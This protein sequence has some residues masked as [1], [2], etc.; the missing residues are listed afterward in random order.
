MRYEDIISIILIAVSYYLFSNEFFKF[1]AEINEKKVSLPARSFSF[2]LIYLWFLFASFLELPL[3]MNWFVFLILLGL[4]LHVVCAYDFLISYALSLF[5]V[6]TSLAVNVFLRSLASILMDVPL[7]YFDNSR[8]SLK[9]YP[10]F[11]GFM[12][13]AALLYVLRRLQ[14]TLQL[15]KM[16]RYR[17]SLAFYTWTEVFI[18]TSL[19]IQLLAYSQSGNSLGV[20][21]WG[22][23][24]SVFSMVVLAITI[25]YSL[26]VAALQFYMDK[27]H[28]IRKKLIRDKKDI[29]KLWTLA[30]TD[31]LTGCNNRQ[32]L[33]KR[34]EEYA[35]YGSSITLAFIDVNGL[36]IIN[37]QYG[38]LEGDNYLIGVSQIL[39]EVIGGCNL[40]LFRYGGD[41]FVLMSNTLSVKEITGLLIRA[42]E[43]LKEKPP[44]YERSI[45]FGV[46]H[47]DCVDYQKLLVAADEIMYQNKLNYYETHVRA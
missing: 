11:L 13:M 36:K 44:Y 34:L 17:K 45:S 2:L 19:V 4:E 47:G 22:I 37:D 9:A 46:V 31:M 33:D 30:Y 10:I 42:N 40:D 5:C 38:H 20:K 8:S 15:K 21:I 29:N 14:F 1:S 43:K 39:S 16:L 18:C 25:F 3:V 6:I 28:E 35:G 27:Q 24:A 26:R 23:K 12:V 7:N 32:L 41:E